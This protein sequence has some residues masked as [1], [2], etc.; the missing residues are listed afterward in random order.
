MTAVSF[1]KILFC[2]LLFLLA[3][4]GQSQVV[5]CPPNID[6]EEGSFAG[7]DCKVGTVFSQPGINTIQWAYSQE[8]PNRHTLIPSGNSE[9]D[10]FGLFPISCPNGSGYSIRLGNEFSGAEAEG[11]S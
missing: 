8:T 6:F 11:I 2:I 4:R 3:P 10:R 7:W 1:H 9:Y 5:T